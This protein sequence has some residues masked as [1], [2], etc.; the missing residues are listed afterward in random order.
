MSDLA[1]F[2]AAVLH[3]KVLADTKEEVDQ[4][5]DQVNQL[6][7]RLQK[8]QAVQIVSPS[9]TVYAEG[10]FQDG[11]YSGNPNLWD[12]V[13]TKQLASCPLS[14]LTD[15]KICI[16]GSDKADFVS[17]SQVDGFIGMEQDEDSTYTDG[18]GPIDFHIG[19]M[20]WLHV[21]V[22]PFT[23]EEAFVLQVPRN[24]AAEDMASFLAEEL[25]VDNAGLSV[26]FLA[27][28]FFVSSVRGAIQNLNLDPAYEDE[29]Q[30]RREEREME[31]PPSP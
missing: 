21:K 29:A 9:G 20:G 28:E 5:A 27:L 25:A 16:G 11:F 17:S 18:W 8:L 4:L 6:S 7:E 14:A 1:P 30:R 15:V 22:G 19:G 24:I 23:S 10:Q 2:V 26:R 12:V 3:D 31:G 13:M